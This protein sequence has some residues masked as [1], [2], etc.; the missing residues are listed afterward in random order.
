MSITDGAQKLY[1]DSKLG[2]VVS[3]AVT[4][5]ALGV[6]EWLGS[7]DFSTLPTFAATWGAVLAGQLAGVI[8]AW[9]SKRGT[10]EVTTLDR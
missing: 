10:P 9:A 1:R 3:T 6:V 7:I 5:I 4:T 2:F 8:T